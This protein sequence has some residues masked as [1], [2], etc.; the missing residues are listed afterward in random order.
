M[1]AKALR[2]ALRWGTGPGFGNIA[3]NVPAAAY[4][5]LIGTAQYGSGGVA[6][7]IVK[8]DGRLAI[9]SIGATG[10]CD[11]SDWVRLV[12]TYTIEPDPPQ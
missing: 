11:T 6:P 3:L 1:A 4:T 5:Q 10:N 7:L 2:V 12:G 9:E 8:A